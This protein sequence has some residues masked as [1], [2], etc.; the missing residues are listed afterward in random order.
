MET[1]PVG[2]P[3]K[4]KTPEEMQ[5]AIDAYFAEC[6]EN[7][8]HLTVTGLALAL[9]LTRQG[10][11]EYSQKKDGEFSDTVKRAKLK[12]ENYIEKKLF[13]ANATGSIFNL[14]NN[15]DWKDKTEQDQNIS[16]SLELK[17]ITRTIIDPL[18]GTEHSNA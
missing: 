9:D 10:L 17:K 13:D 14:K 1:N 12:V 5:E 3:P 4:Y 16:G 18:N 2:R 8:E 15:F 6:K 7:K 11:I